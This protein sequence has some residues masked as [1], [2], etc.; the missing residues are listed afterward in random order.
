MEA[1]LADLLLT[2]ASPSGP[3]SLALPGVE[4]LDGAALQLEPWDWTR[5]TGMP[6]FSRAYMGDGRVV[7]RAHNA[8]GPSVRQLLDDMLSSGAIPNRGL[9]NSI[10]RQIDLA[11]IQAL[12]NHLESLVAEGRITAGTADLILVA[13]EAVEAG[14]TSAGRD[15]R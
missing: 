15:M 11:P 4:L 5:L 2:E 6:V 12:A 14:G 8:T 13:A 10:L 3:V 9:A 1:S 7:L